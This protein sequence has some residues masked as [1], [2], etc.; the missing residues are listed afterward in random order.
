MDLSAFLPVVQWG[1]P[2]LVI[3]LLLVS[4]YRMLATDKLVTGAT[5]KARLEDA[6][7]RAEIYHEM[8]TTTLE[9]L[10]EQGQHNMTV[11]TEIRA[12]VSSGRIGPST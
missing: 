2:Y 10:R 4:M 8:A 11:L 3:F 1:G 9:A 7:Q 12:L 5:H 6:N